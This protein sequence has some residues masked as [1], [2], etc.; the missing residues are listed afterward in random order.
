M[1]APNINTQLKNLSNSGRL[2]L[3]NTNNSGR[4]TIHAPAPIVY[5]FSGSWSFMDRNEACEGLNYINAN[6]FSLTPLASVT[7]GTQIYTNA[8]LTTTPNQAYITLNGIS[9]ANTGGVLSAGQAC[10]SPF[11]SWRSS[12]TYGGNNPSDYCTPSYSITL[13]SHTNDITILGNHDMTPTNSLYTNIGLT[14]KFTGNPS[15]I[16]GYYKITLIGGSGLGYGVD[17]DGYGFIGSYHL[18]S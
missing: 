16:G 12:N 15:G 17:V 11:Y 4:L 14:T 3:T 5:N 6:Y 8:E 7:N 2:T 1:S 13:Y 9:Y 10:A 18:C